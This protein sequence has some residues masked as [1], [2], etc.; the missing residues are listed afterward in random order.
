MY[1][2][3]PSAPEYKKTKGMKDI[4]DAKQIFRKTDNKRKS[5]QVDE[6]VIKNKTV[7]V[8]DDTTQTKD[9]S[10]QK[11]VESVKMKTKHFKNKK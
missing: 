4:I 7:K 10:L 2:V 8:N 3:D 6:N 11:L 9:T 1:N 5:S